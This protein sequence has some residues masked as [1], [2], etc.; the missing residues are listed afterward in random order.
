MDSIRSEIH[1]HGRGMRLYTECAIV[2]LIFSNPRLA[3]ASVGAIGMVYGTWDDYL[4]VGGVK[5]SNRNCRFL[6]LHMGSLLW[7]SAPS[8][9]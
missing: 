7:W 6:L 8:S 3:Y 9:L 2:D 4:F 1:E 5:I